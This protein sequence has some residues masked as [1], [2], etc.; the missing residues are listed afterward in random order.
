MP[1]IEDLRSPISGPAKQGPVLF[2][3][4]ETLGTSGQSQLTT[5]P[6]ESSMEKSGSSRK[7]PSSSQSVPSREYSVYSTEP[8]TDA[9]SIPETGSFTQSGSSRAASGEKQYS[10]G[11]K[12]SPK[13]GVDDMKE[14]EFV[15]NEVYPDIKR[16]E[17]LNTSGH[18]DSVPQNLGKRSASDA[19][20]SDSEENEKSMLRICLSSDGSLSESSSVKSTELNSAQISRGN[21]HRTRSSNIKP[22]LIPRRARPESHSDGSGANHDIPDPKMKVT[23]Q[24]DGPAWDPGEPHDPEDFNPQTKIASDELLNSDTDESLAGDLEPEST[25]NTLTGADAGQSISSTAESTSKDGGSP[26]LA[27][28]VRPH[29]D[30]QIVVSV[31]EVEEDPF[32]TPRANESLR[33]TVVTDYG[34]DSPTPKLPKL[35]TASLDKRHIPTGSVDRSSRQM[36]E[37]KLDLVEQTLVVSNPLRADFATYKI[38]MT[39]EV[40]LQKGRMGDWSHLKVPGLPRMKNGEN[41]WFLFQIPESVG[42]EFRTTSFGTHK[43]V[44]DCFLAELVQSGDLNIPLRLCPRSFYGTLGDFTVDQEIQSEHVT[45]KH[46]QQRMVVYNAVCSLRLYKRCF[47]SERCSFYL[48]IDGGPE[49]DYHCDMNSTSGTPAFYRLPS[50]DRPI[51]VSCIH[52]VCSPRDLGAFCVSWCV[53]CRC[54]EGLEWLPRV[55]SG[56]TLTSGD[57]SH[58]R[59]VMSRLSKSYVTKTIL[60][61]LDVKRGRHHM[62]DNQQVKPPSKGYSIRRMLVCIAMSLVAVF[63]GLAVLIHVHP[64]VGLWLLALRES[65]RSSPKAEHIPST[66]RAEFA[67]T[68]RIE[69][70]IARIP[71]MSSTPMI[72]RSSEDRRADT[73]LSWRDRLDYFLGWQG[74]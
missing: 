7:A 14:N 2:K 63:L 70:S 6:E 10:S 23:D 43:F 47:F 74:P 19:C 40:E 32:E 16:L 62:K 69:P 21:G 26:R 49:G 61:P 58:L 18:E 30:S 22:S 71:R 39:A 8:A 35:N 36:H 51:G 44:E 45:H 68:R 38:T 55:F 73:Q 66:P 41:G 53:E 42:M 11:V 15:E 60:D 50:G 64:D 25:Q 1:S 46:S 34:D 59:E 65:V 57:K 27:T 37:P 4:P 67:S 29:T 12:E 48:W 24:L 52:I 3:T 28:P 5:I 72:E 33:E 54:N 13:L 17:E 20:L 56:P 31:T 9:L